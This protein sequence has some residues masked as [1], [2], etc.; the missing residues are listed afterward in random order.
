MLHASEAIE[1]TKQ[2]SVK[3]ELP[4]IYKLVDECMNQ[5]EKEIL[6]AA[7]KGLSCTDFLPPC[8]WLQYSVGTYNTNT[9]DQ[10]D[11]VVAP[12]SKAIVNSLNSNGYRCISIHTNCFKDWKIKVVWIDYG[13][14]Q[15]PLA[16]E[17]FEK[18]NCF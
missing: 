10:L 9:K 8:V 7:A 15:L 3:K 13:S 1:L 17:N 18:Q 12:L 16:H 4:C 14:S 5:I 6:N 2:H 11:S